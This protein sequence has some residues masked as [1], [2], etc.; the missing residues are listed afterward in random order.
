MTHVSNTR[1][2]TRLAGLACAL[3]LASA[4]SSTNNSAS[5]SAAGSPFAPG[6]TAAKPPAQTS[7]TTVSFSGF[8]ASTLTVTVNTNTTSSVGQPYV[9]QGK[10]QLQ[11]LVDSLG[12]PVPLGTVG[13]SYVR[14]DTAPGGGMNPVN[15]LTAYSVDLDNLDALTGGVVHN[16]K[17]GDH[18]AFRA[19]YVTGGGQTHVDGHESAETP[20]TIVCAVVCTLGQGY[21][22]TG[23]PGAWPLS[24]VNNGL[25]LGSASYTA[26]EL[27]SIFN[28]PVAG[29][30]LISLA[31]QLIA[32]K[33]NVAHGADASAVASAIAAADALIGS[34]IVPPAGGGSLA[35]GAT[36]ALVQALD[37]Y[38]SGLTGPGACTP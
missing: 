11:I 24:A 1:T 5:P 29:N 19:H 21:W 9:D 26:A 4:C 32:A 33:L 30:G 37:N 31:H 17:C 38:N 28:T 23:Y 15:G 13:A 6:G 36:S 35:P 2:V 16:A 14:F 8:D 12:Q 7:G 27:E 25:T 34:L 10:I 20:Y 22:K 3:A 18:I